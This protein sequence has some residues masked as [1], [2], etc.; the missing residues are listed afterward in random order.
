[1]HLQPMWAVLSNGQ[2]GLFWLGITLLPTIKDFPLWLY[3][4]FAVSS[5]MLPSQSDRHAWLPLG[6]TI[7]VLIAL[8]ILAGVGPWM[9]TYI[10]PPLNSF[11]ST[12]AI[13]FGLSA[14]LHLVLILPIKLIHFLL[15]KLTGVDIQ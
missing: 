5:T 10:T 14:V 13:I 6:V 8:A 15:A 3:L 4:T 7:V 12:A 1:M 2:F 9:L 11:L